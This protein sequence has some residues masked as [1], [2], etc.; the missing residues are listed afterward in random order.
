MSH[1]VG[2]FAFYVLAAK[3]LRASPA[4]AGVSL[5]PR[6]ITAVKRRAV[7]FTFFARKSLDSGETRGHGL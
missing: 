5:L 1:C 2:V 6:E 3:D 4:A 7:G